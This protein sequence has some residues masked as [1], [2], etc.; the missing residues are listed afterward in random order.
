MGFIRNNPVEARPYCENFSIYAQN[1]SVFNRNQLETFK[2]YKNYAHMFGDNS[3]FPETLDHLSLTSQG[4]RV[5]VMVSFARGAQWA[6]K[7]CPNVLGL[8]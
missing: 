7:F 5:K 8:G 2:F 3:F 4:I 6:E 1:L